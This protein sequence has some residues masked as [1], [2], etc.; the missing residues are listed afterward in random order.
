MNLLHSTKKVS[1]VQNAGDELDY[2]FIYLHGFTLLCDII[3]QFP[4]NYILVHCLCTY[5]DNVM[6]IYIYIYIYA[7]MHNN[8]WL[9]SLSIDESHG[10]V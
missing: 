6:Y 5:T 7:I 9:H 3:G 2:L 4:N 1:T 10:Y 8:I